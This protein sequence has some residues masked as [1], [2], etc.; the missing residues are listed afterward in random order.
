[1]IVEHSIICPPLFKVVLKRFRGLFSPA[2]FLLQKSGTCEKTQCSF[3]CD[4]DLKNETLKFA[5]SCS[6][7]VFKRVL[8]QD[9]VTVSN[10]SRA[11]ANFSSLD[12]SPVLN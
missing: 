7:D 5:M 11:M 10:C 8:K 12:G 4:I 3:W 9:A 2:L 1:M 6:N